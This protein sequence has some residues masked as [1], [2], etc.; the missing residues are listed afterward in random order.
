MKY[1]QQAIQF[2]KQQKTRRM[3]FFWMEII[4]TSTNKR[5]W[6]G[7]TTTTNDDDDG[8]LHP[9]SKN[10]FFLSLCCCCCCCKLNN[11]NNNKTLQIFTPPRYIRFASRLS[12][13]RSLQRGM[14]CM[15]FNSTQAHCSLNLLSMRLD[16]D[17]H[18]CYRA[19]MFFFYSVLYIRVFCMFFLYKVKDLA[20]FL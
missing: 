7:T 15:L 2:A 18:N 14:K 8:Q 17:I 1:R 4:I 10:C 11:N 20:I 6:K 19:K 9:P 5:T 13:L 12:F 16:I 3:F